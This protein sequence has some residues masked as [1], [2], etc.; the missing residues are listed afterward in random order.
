MIGNLAD[1]IIA[2]EAGDLDES[3]VVDLFQRLVDTGVAWHLQG[4]Y[5][6]MAHDL[7]N[8]GLVTPPTREES[9]A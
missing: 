3:E 6:R 1:Q 7:I 5:G 4:S 9:R 8:A 2:Y